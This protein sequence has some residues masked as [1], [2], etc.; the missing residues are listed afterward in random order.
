[1]GNLQRVNK[2]RTKRALMMIRNILI[3]CRKLSDGNIDRACQD[4][5]ASLICDYS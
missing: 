5:I 1:M 2:S 3:I 4:R